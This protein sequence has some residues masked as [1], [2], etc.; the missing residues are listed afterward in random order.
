MKVYVIGS[1]RNPEVRLFSSALRDRGHEVFDDWMASGPDADDHWKAY[2]EERGRTYVEALEKSLAA[3]NQFRFD[4][5]HLNA[6]DA[7]V[8][9]LPAGRSAHLELGWALGKGKAGFIVLQDKEE[10]RWDIMYKFATKVFR[11]WDDCLNHFGGTV[12]GAY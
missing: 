5:T 6:A 9:L 10:P 1:L 7:V 8:L 4:Y 2:E 3:D 11:T 12:K